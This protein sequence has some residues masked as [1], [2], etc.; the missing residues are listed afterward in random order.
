VTEVL[1]PCPWPLDASSLGRELHTAWRLAQEAGA[2]AIA[3]RD[4]RDLGVEYKPGDEPVTI[5]DR[6]ASAIIVEGLQA[7]F[8]D[9][10]VISEELPDDPARLTARRVWYIDPIDGTKDFIRGDIGYSIM[11]GLCVDHVPTLGVVFQPAGPRT[12]VAAPGLGAAYADASGTR[13]LVRSEVSSIDDVRLVASKSHRGGD[14]DQVKTTLGINNELNIGSVGVKL[15][16]IALGERDLYVNPSSHCKA[17]DTCAP[18][19]ILRAAGGVMTDLHGD[20]LPYNLA[21]LGR[22]RGLVASNGRVHAAVLARLATLFPR[23]T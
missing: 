16:L 8:P 11:I 15:S 2:A 1:P 7:T 17:W 6:R 14:I 19:A 21:D 9:D 3:I 4:G 22:R 10:I 13:P 20:P 18:E 5:A 23:P 12:F